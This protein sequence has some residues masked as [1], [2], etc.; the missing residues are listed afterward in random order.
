MQDIVISLVADVARNFIH[1]RHV[2]LYLGLK[3]VPILVSAKQHPEYLRH[4]L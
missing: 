3:R 2:D 1:N 4:N